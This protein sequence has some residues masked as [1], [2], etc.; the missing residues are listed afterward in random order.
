[1]NPIALQLQ[2]MLPMPNVAGASITNNFS[3]QGPYFFDSDHG[4]GKLNWNPT[5][6]LTTFAHLGIV[7]W[8]DEDASVFGCQDGVN[9]AN[10]S[11]AGTST[12]RAGSPATRMA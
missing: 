3:G 9:P 12:R 10:L 4:D 5:P 1:M 7:D 11:E 2:S 8:I 6:K